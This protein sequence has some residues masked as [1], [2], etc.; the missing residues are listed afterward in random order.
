MLEIPISYTSKREER[1]H[2]SM[3]NTATVSDLRAEVARH[4]DVDPS[5]IALLFK[6]TILSP[7]TH[8]SDVRFSDRVQIQ[9][10][11]KTKDAVMQTPRLGPDRLIVSSSSKRSLL[12]EPYW[13]DRPFAHTSQSGL[14]RHS[15]S[16]KGDGTSSLLL[17]QVY[18]TI[19]LERVLP[20]SMGQQGPGGL[21]GIGLPEPQIARSFPGGGPPQPPAPP[22]PGSEF[23][24]KL[25]GECR[26]AFDQLTVDEQAAVERLH[27]FGVDP[28]QAVELFIAAEKNIERAFKLWERNKQ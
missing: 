27:E 16:V 10:F 9:V 4:H 7:D 20:T 1:T 14:P 26:Q 8:L 6:G 24:M 13:P 17:H 11:I 23:Q 15:T 3:S 19:E 22:P 18:S 25:N 5:T 12:S 2:V 21:L 28:N